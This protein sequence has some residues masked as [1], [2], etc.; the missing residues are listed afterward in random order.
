MITNHGKLAKVSGKP[1]KTQTINHFLI[2][3]DW[4]LVDLPGYG[5]A[6]TSKKKRNLFQ[7][8]IEQYILK[9]PNLIL[10]YVLVDCRIEPQ[11]IDVE[12]IN[13]LGQHQVPFQLVFTKSDKLKPNA[14]EQ[15][16]SIYNAKLEETWEEVPSIIKTSSISKTGQDEI[17]SLVEENN[18]LWRA[19][20]E[21]MH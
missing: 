15:N 14:L 21:Q 5:Y 17:L 10:L 13:W 4:Y 19:H 3:D 16:L 12:F 7:H 1:G 11:K 2:N 18:P 20:Y 9:R 6:K 8:F